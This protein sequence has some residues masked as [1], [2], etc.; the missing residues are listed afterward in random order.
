M[1]PAIQPR[2]IGFEALVSGCKRV[3]SL[4]VNA[5]LVENYLGFHDGISGNELVVLLA[6]QATT[7]AV[8]IVVKEGEDST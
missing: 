6:Q 1:T 2:R 7:L 5:A 3:S 4:A 8:R